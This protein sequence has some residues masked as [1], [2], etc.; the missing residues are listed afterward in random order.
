MTFSKAPPLSKPP[1][2][3]KE[4]EKL[5]IE[6]DGLVLSIPPSLN[7]ISTEDSPDSPDSPSSAEKSSLYIIAIV[8][9]IAIAIVVVFRGY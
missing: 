2:R 1:G 5:K 8:A 4:N 9:I 3:K 6:K 7:Q